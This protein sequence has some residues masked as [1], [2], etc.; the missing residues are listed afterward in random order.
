MPIL[1]VSSCVVGYKLR[2]G[3]AVRPS[4]APGACARAT[5]NFFAARA[6]TAKPLRRRAQFV[7]ARTR[8]ERNSRWRPAGDAMTRVRSPANEA[9]ESLIVPKHSIRSKRAC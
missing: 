6:R 9:F 1:R 3:H 8:A 7:N 4:S 2:A 5:F